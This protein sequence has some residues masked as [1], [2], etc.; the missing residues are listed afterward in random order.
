MLQAIITDNQI[1]P[2]LQQAA[3]G[4]RAVRINDQRHLAPLHD[5]QRLVASNRRRIG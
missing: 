3:G 1:Y 4:G 2:L 5:K